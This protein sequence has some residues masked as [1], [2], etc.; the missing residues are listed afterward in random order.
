MNS[1]LILPAGTKYSL[2]SLCGWSLV[3]NIYVLYFD[4]T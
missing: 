4:A 3:H 1:E 2:L